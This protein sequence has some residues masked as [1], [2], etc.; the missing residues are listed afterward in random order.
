M[1]GRITRIIG[2]FALVVSAYGAYSLL[3]VPLIEPEAVRPDSGSLSE[4]ELIDAR[5]IVQNQRIDLQ[6]W[7]HAGDW[8]LSSPKILETSQGKLLLKQHERLPDPHFVKMTPCSLIFMP[9]G[10]YANEEERFRQAIVLRAPQGAILQFDR[11]FD[12]KRGD[13]SKVVGGQLIGPVTI[14]SDQR[15]PGPEDDLWIETRDV[16]LVDNQVTTPHRIKFRHGLNRGEGEE[17]FI[18][19]ATPAE[20]AV[21]PNASRFGSMKRLELARDVRLRLLPGN[22]NLFPSG[23]NP[24]TPN[25][26]ANKARPQ[27]P[28]EVTCQGPFHFDLI[29]YVATFHDRVNVVR[30]NP[31]A[32]SDQLTCEVLDLYF[33]AVA[34]SANAAAPAAESGSPKLRPT[35]LAARGNPVVLTS[36]SNGVQARGQR[37]E[38]DVEKQSGKLFD[39]E[40]AWLR[41]ESK[42]GLKPQEIHAQELEFESDPKNPSGPPRMMLARGEGWL[43]GN[44]P[45]GHPPKSKSQKQIQARWTH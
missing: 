18:E 21:R 44:V 27:P 33:D 35:R 12:L 31:D 34:P 5:G 14:R 9:E 39:K 42:A 1:F 45:E 24:P 37:L 11:P 38:Y 20:K 36:P 32:P 2:S 19:L 25:A 6:Y 17:L 30:L 10:A 29:Q 3:A 26:A 40:D 13:I 8:E 4:Q 16:K 23:A 43:R 41:Q 15:L 22:A 7:F 28:V